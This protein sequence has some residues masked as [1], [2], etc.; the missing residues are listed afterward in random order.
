MTLALQQFL[1]NDQAFR[2]DALEISSF[3]VPAFLN[4]AVV[5]PTTAFPREQENILGTLLT[6]KLAPV[7]EDWIDEGKKTGTLVN[8]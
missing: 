5:H 1:N 6:K 2:N 7:I 4:S 3:N 8:G